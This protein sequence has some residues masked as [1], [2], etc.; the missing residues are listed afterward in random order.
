MWRISSVLW[1]IGTLADSAVR[2]TMAYTLPVDLVPALGAA[3]YAGTSAVII[4]VTNVYYVTAGVYDRRS[5]MY[6][7]TETAS[8]N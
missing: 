2:V 4:V 8:Q 3:L 6:G 1:G 7:P 5:A